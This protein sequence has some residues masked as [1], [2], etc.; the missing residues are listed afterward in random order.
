V[1]SNRTELVERCDRTI[2]LGHRSGL[3]PAD[4]PDAGLRR[5]A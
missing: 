1:A 5:P 3:S 4:V 2:V